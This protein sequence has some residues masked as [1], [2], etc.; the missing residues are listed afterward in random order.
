MA[1]Q[2]SN[3]AAKFQGLPTQNFVF[4]DDNFPASGKFFDEFFVQQIEE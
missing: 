4:L 1:V 2:N 3:F